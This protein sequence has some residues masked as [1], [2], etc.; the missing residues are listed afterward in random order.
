MPFTESES[1]RSPVCKLLNRVQP[2]CS[3]RF[4]RIPFETIRD[5]NASV[6]KFSVRM[7]VEAASIMRELKGRIR[8]NC[9]PFWNSCLALTEGSA[10]LGTG[11]TI[12]AGNHRTSPDHLLVLDCYDRESE[13]LWFDRRFAADQ[14]L[15]DTFTVEINRSNPSIAELKFASEPPKKWLIR[16]LAG[17]APFRSIPPEAAAAATNGRRGIFSAAPDRF[18]RT[19]AIATMA[20]ECPA[21][22]VVS[23]RELLELIWKMTPPAVRR[24]IDEGN[25]KAVW[26]RE[27]L[28]VIE[29]ERFEGRGRAIPVTR[30][31]FPRKTRGRRRNPRLLVA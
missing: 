4:L 28:D 27:E 2:P 18:E 9:F 23:Q 14:D 12:D 5:S 7:G 13:R 11:V 30:V 6:L 16:Y 26:I 21:G 25:L 22:R 31:T 3:Q 15:A 1:W 10:A 17:F 20:D 8:L 24:N 19:D 29:D